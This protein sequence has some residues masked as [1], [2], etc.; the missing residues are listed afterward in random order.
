MV[1][2][3]VI[4]AN[5]QSYRAMLRVHYFHITLSS[6]DVSAFEPSLLNI[7]VDICRSVSGYAYSL[8]HLVKWKNLPFVPL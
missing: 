4:N 8:L 5:N 1:F 6:W 7:A 3:I 2:F